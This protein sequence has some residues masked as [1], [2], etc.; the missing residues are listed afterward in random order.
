MNGNH[1]RLRRERE[2]TR[3]KERGRGRKGGRADKE[4]ERRAKEEEDP[5]R[6]SRRRIYRL[7]EVLRSVG[8]KHREV[9]NDAPPSR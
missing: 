1:E 5:G 9:N 8:V 3:E 2:S 6:E 4:E 7:P